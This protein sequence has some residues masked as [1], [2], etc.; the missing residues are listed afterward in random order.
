M[1]TVQHTKESLSRAFVHAIAGRAG[2]NCT[3]ERAFDYGIDG[4]FRPVTIRGNRRIESSFPLDYQLK[5]TKSWNIEDTNIGYNLE[6]KT[7][8]DLV[9]RD[10]DGVG[11]VLILLCLP[12]EDETWV[13]FSEEYMTL[14]K[15]CYYTVLSGEP[16]TNEN[17]TR[18]ILIPRSNVFTAD[19]LRELLEAERRRKVGDGEA[20]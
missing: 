1:I 16:V 6:S 8:N 4:T 7:Y 19:A 15:C 9:T 5:A 2:V 20:A 18:K 3:G 13:E 11:A 12:P 17:S 14:R 10:P